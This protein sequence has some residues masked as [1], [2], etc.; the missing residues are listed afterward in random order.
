MI[1]FTNSQ[2][3][4]KGNIN[5]VSQN[6]AII[7]KILSTTGKNLYT[8]IAGRGRGVKRLLEHKDVEKDKIP[9]GTKFKYVGVK[10]KEIAEREEKLIIKRE[11]PKYNVQHKKEK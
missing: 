10:T 6:K 5:D 4:I 3:F 1:K 11:N 7:Y 9:G 8:G 2:K